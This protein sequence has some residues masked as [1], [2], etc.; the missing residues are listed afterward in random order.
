MGA[1]VPSGCRITPN[2]SVNENKFFNGLPAGIQA[3]GGFRRQYCHAVDIVPAIYQALGL[4]LPGEVNGYPQRPLEGVSF[5]ASFDDPSADTGKH[6]QYYSMLGTR[7]LWHQG[8]KASSL[9]PAAPNAW[10]DFSAQRWELFITDRDPS[11]CHDLEPVHLPPGWRRSARVAGP[12]HP[13][14]VLHDRR[15]AGHRLRAGGRGPVLPGL[16]I[17]RPRPLCHRRQAGLRVQLRRAGHAGRGVRP[18]GPGRARDPRPPSS[19]K[20]TACPRRAR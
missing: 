1:P 19:G 18:A 20:A 8:W 5:A 16:A 3:R 11:E 14:P 10:G 17:R 6:T 4:E 7:A 2:G 13:R 9:G 15:G 12:E